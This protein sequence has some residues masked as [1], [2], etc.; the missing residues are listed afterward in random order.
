M[1][2]PKTRGNIDVRLACETGKNQKSR[3][4][5]A[6]EKAN[7]GITE[8]QERVDRPEEAI[9]G[10]KG[11]SHPM[12]LGQNNWHDPLKKLKSNEGGNSRVK[13][14]YSE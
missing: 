13:E 14:G 1:R 4:K 9:K 10:E 2:E 7:H 3:A 11:L 8:T 5:G 12:I 6:K